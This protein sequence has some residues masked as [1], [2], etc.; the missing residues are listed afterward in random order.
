[1][2]GARWAALALPL[3]QRAR[4]DRGWRDSAAGATAAAQEPATFMRSGGPA[5][6]VTRAQR[7]ARR[8]SRSDHSVDP[9]ARHRAWRVA[10][11]TI[12]RAAS[13]RAQRV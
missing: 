8:S 1:V 7:L 6:D 11:V 10:E 5:I 12:W 9:A 2:G 3:H 13:E 4:S